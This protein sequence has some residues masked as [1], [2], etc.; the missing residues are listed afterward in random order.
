MPNT[1]ISPQLL[2]IVEIFIAKSK[3]V[4]PLR[5]HLGN[6]VF[7][8]RLIPTVQKTLSETR[9]QVEPL[10]HLAQQKRSAIG[11]DRPAVKTGHDFTLP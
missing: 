11:T 8:Q 5:N 9:Q 10:I 4:N 6:R 7:D 3:S 1:G 2:V